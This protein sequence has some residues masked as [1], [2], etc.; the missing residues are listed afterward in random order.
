M[1]SFETLRVPAIGSVMRFSFRANASAYRAYIRVF[2]NS[3]RLGTDKTDGAHEERL[4]I[5]PLIELA[6]IQ[7]GVKTTPR[8]QLLMRA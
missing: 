8:E 2:Y 5:R 1:T 6:V 4:L 3:A 7:L